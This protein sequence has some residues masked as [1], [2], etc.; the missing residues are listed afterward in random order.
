MTPE[1]L[2]SLPFLHRKQLD[3]EFG[4]AFSLRVVVMPNVTQ[5]ITLRGSTRT[6]PFSFNIDLDGSATYEEYNFPLTDIPLFLS[7]IDT[8]KLIPP[9]F[10]WLSV[11]LQVNGNDIQQLFSGFPS[12]YNSLSWPAINTAPPYGGAPS[13]Y[14]TTL[15]DPNAGSEISGSVPSV[16]WYKLRSL[17][18]RLITSAT[19]ASR[20][21]HFKFTTATN[22]IIG[23][24]I[25]PAVQT[26][27]QTI[28]YTLQMSGGSPVQVDDN[29]QIILI[30]DN[31]WL[32]PLSTITTETVNLQAG[33]NFGQPFPFV[34]LALN[35]GT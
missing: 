1:E 2:A 22:W 21:V 7:A 12:A 24:F 33:D 9:G 10:L 29:D 30:P 20:R 4:A 15:S 11:W 27:G 26:A 34:E 8:N 17:R 32:P 25:A 5:Q 16:Y 18:V 14:S 23:E 6:A 3:Y 35:A 31:F 28:D 19:V 13:S